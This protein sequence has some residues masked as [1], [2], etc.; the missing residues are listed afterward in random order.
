MGN[1]I[2]FLSIKAFKS[3]CFLSKETATTA[4]FLFSLE[5]FSRSCSWSWLD[6]L[7]L[8]KNVKIKGFCSE[9]AC[10][11]VFLPSK[12]GKVNSC[13]TAKAV[14]QIKT[15]KNKA[16]ICL[17]FIQINYTLR[18]DYVN[19]IFKIMCIDNKYVKRYKYKQSI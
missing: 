17:A 12:L 9:I 2:L 3:F 14:K 15:Q 18:S 19:I 1:V 13:S 10:K 8:V 7:Q 16:K 11:L 5:I 4:T 6:L